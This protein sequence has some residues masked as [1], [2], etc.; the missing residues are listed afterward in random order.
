MPEVAGV[1]NTE[2]ELKNMYIVRIT[3]PIPFDM[4]VQDLGMDKRQ[5]TRWNPDY[6]MFVYKTYP[7]PYYSL[8]LPKDKTDLFLQKKEALTKKAKV[9]YSQN[10]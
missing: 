9:Y 8:R 7:T 10:R 4:M 6:D 5:L 2:E 1:G 3:E